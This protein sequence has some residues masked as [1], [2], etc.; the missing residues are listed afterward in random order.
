MTQ[1]VNASAYDLQRVH[2]LGYIADTRDSVRVE[3]RAVLGF[4]ET[5]QSVTWQSEDREIV[6]IISAAI[7]ET[8]TSAILYSPRDGES[9]I[10]AKATTSAGRELS[11][12]MWVQTKGG[13]FD[14]GQT[15]G[16][17][18]VTVTV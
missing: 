13:V 7:D 15:A 6:S 1:T 2:R 9:Y 17:E 14:D 10:R 18:T 11:Q 3:F 12:Y 8:G 5:L 4:G 16:Q